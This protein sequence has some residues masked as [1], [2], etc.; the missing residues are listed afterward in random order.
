MKILKSITGAL[1]LLFLLTG[2]AFAVDDDDAA[3]VFYATSLSGGGS[4]SLDGAVSGVS[5]GKQDIAIVTIPGS[6]TG[7]SAFAL[8]KATFTSEAENLPTVV[9]PDDVGG[10]VTSWHKMDFGY[11]DLTI[12]NKSTSGASLVV[13]PPSGT[14][15]T[16]LMHNAIIRNDTAS[17]VWWALPSIS[18]TSV[19][20]FKIVEFASG[21]GVTVQTSD[22]QP[23]FG[24]GIS[25]SSTFVLPTG[26]QGESATFYGT[27][28]GTS[29]VW[30]VEAT[31]SWETRP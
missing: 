26:N 15:F 25:G 28:S 14:T 6:I 18:G 29:K 23:F 12:A 8:Y 2:T 21:A 30:Y 27:A 10:G 22:S 17:W 31:S 5:V 11:P 3:T 7:T 24:D 13:S 9:R 4:N 16:Q 20:V 1:V 19:I